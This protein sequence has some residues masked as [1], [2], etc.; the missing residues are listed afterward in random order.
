MEIKLIN[1]RD[2]SL[3]FIEQILKNR[4]ITESAKDFFDLTWDCVNDSSNLDY[5]SEAAELYKKHIND[6]S[7]IAVLVDVDMDGF[8]SAALLFNYTQM[9]IEY[10]NWDKFQGEIIPVFHKDKTHGLNDKEMMRRIRDEV[11]P[12][13]FVIPDASGTAEQYE[14]LTNLGIDILV[15]DHH[16][17]SERGNGKNIIVVNNQQSKNYTNKDLSGVGVTW[18][19]CRE[20][21][22][23]NDL[24]CADQFLDLVAIGN[25]GDVMDLRSNETRFLCQEGLKNIESPFLQYLQFSSYSLKDK[26]FSPIAVSF[27]V[28]PLFNAVCRIGDM[29]E[30]EMLFK[31]LINKSANEM[32]D[33][34]KRGH[35]GEKVRLVEEGCRL[36]SNARSRQNTRKDKLIQMIDDV[37]SEE[38]LFKNPVIVLAFDDFKED[39]RDLSG[40]VATGL[41][42]YYDRPV[43]LTFLNDDGSYSGSLRA[44]DNIPA[45]E[46]FKDQCGESGF[47]TFV[48]GHPQAAGIGIKAGCVDNLNEYFKNKYSDV[49]TSLCE[50]VDFI[51]DANDPQLPSL[52]EELVKYDDI[53]GTNINAPKI[54]ITNV[55]IGLSTMNL[56]GAKKNTLKITLP[57]IELINFKSSQT[58][59]DSL[60]LPYDG[61]E[62]FYYATVICHDPLI[63]EFRGIRTPQ[64]QFSTYSLGT[65]KYDF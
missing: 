22:K 8:S 53:W 14:A 54:A 37:I 40:L 62:Q 60:K 15:L 63:N 30:K 38:K 31:C 9:Q 51:I 44:P 52:I 36:A 42:D 61:I 13:L 20:L 32:V 25:I 45:F 56:M 33:N 41:S 19:F 48:A 5:I 10:G 3:S 43:I 64:L 4:G 28:A 7:K 26:H 18:Q 34:G 58:E 57:N 46:N 35:N 65:P 16:D 1:E 23:T 47:C 17:M 6:N 24:V 21:D 55:K 29:Q 59:Y 2:P 49:D 27:N 50:K 11:K 12:N 39:Y